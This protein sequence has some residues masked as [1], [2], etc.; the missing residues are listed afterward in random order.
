MTHKAAELAGLTFDEY[1]ERYSSP[2]DTPKMAAH[3][4][5]GICQ[6]QEQRLMKAVA[7]AEAVICAKCG[8]AMEASHAED[9]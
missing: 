3:A 7:A 9:L 2:T 8:A 1:W 4:A 5:W 6:R